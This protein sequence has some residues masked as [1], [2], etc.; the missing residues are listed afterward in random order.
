[1]EGK[2]INALWFALLLVGVL[3]IFYAL[4]GTIRYAVLILWILIA[5]F[6]H[7]FL[8]PAKK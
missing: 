3:V 2:K 8:V 6:L 1:L 5:A 4:A 7:R